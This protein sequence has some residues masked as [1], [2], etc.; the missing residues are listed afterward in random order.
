M[1]GVLGSHITART[2]LCTLPHTAA[3]ALP[4]AHCPARYCTKQCA[5]PHTSALPHTAKLSHNSYTTKRTAA[6]CRSHCANCVQTSTVRT[7]T[8]YCTYTAVRAA[9]HSRSHC[10]KIPHT[11]ALPHTATHCRTAAQ[12]HSTATTCHTHYHTLPSALPDRCTLP[13]ALPYTTNQAHCYIL[14]CAMRAHYRAY[15]RTQR[16]AAHCRTAARCH[17]ATCALLHCRTLPS[18]LPHTAAVSL[19]QTAAHYRTT[20][21]CCTAAH[22]RTTAHTAHY[23]LHCHTLPHALRA[24]RGH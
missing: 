8:H 7:A 12:P 2:P 1:R 17:T 21:H 14:S 22:C 11:A 9:A 3:S 20:T 15:C 4:H 23:Q 10:R 5:L 13:R 6:H 18:A 24:V 16:T 19:P